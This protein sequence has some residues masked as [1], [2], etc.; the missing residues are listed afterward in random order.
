MKKSTTLSGNG[1]VKGELTAD[2][3]WGIYMNGSTYTC[4]LNGPKFEFTGQIAVGGS[5]NNLV[6]E[7]GVLAFNPNSSSDATILRVKSLTLGT[8]MII[9]KPEGGV[10][11]DTTQGIV[12]NGSL[13][14]GHAVIS[15]KGDVNLDGTVTIAD[16]VAVL[17]AMAGQEVAGNPDVNGDKEVSIADFVA[18]L[19]IMAGQ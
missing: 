1:S 2:D 6:I 4:T 15:Q 13:Y 7:K 18:V 17:N 9:A 19:N 8:G 16:A 12:V 14:H 11:D 5:A 10:F 3:G